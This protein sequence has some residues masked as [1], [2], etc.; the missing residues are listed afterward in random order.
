[1][2]VLV[3]VESFTKEK[4]VK[5]YLTKAFQGDGRTF[6]V[7]ASGGH[8]C[9]LVKANMGISERTLEPVYEIIKDKGKHVSDLKRLVSEH[10]VVYLASDND[11]EGEAIAW[12][13]LK[14]L[15]PKIYKRIVFNE[16]TMQALKNAVNNPRDVNLHMV[17]SQQAR[18]VLDRLV[19]YNLTKVLWKNFSGGGMLTAGRVQSVVL[20]MLVEREVDVAKFETERYWNV[21]GT[22]TNGVEEAK[23]CFENTIHK[24]VKKDEMLKVLQGFAKKNEYFVISSDTKRVN[25]YPN[26]PLTTSTLQQAAFSKGFSIKETMKVAQE[27]YEKGHITYMRTDST[28]LSEEFV[29][30]AKAHVGRVFGNDYVSPVSRKSERK[31][32]NAQEAHEAVRPT[33]NKHGELSLPSEVSGLNER[34]RKL[35][36]LIYAHTVASIMTPAVYDELT[37]RVGHDS[38]TKRGLYFRGKTR[39]LLFLGY[40]RVYGERASDSGS[41]SAKIDITSKKPLRAKEIRGNC[42]WTIPPQRYN[43]S[44]VIKAMEDNGIGRPSTYVNILNKVYDRSYVQKMDMRGPI[45]VYKDYV[46]KGA[47]KIDEDIRERELYVETNK[48]VPTK[49]GHA[50]DEFLR[51]RFSELVNV[52]FT[53]DMESSLDSIAEKHTT[54]EAVIRPFHSMLSAKVKEMVE[55]VGQKTVIEQERHVFKIDNESMVVRRAR[56]GPVIELVDSKRFIPLQPYMKLYGKSDISEIG[57]RDIKFLLGFPRAYKH[58][59]VNYKSYGFYVEN[60]RSKKTLSI[61]AFKNK[62]YKDQLARGELS[63]IDELKL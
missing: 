19:G 29:Q 21:W 7:K 4:T 13:L 26:K 9:D 45:K 59:T 32:K 8:I 34:Q 50:V 62:Q 51:K 35:Y 57:E 63:F 16:I 17:S 41:S 27:L 54:Y 18:R 28:N 2:K 46:L 31:Q 23:L 5:A 22:F 47:G 44:S 12:H 15:K 37:V 3:I 58:Y 30:S 14:V 56:Y 49:S 60:D 61:N 55:D 52:K 25:E 24:F 6:T 40:L 10:D 53:G 36:T 42:V 1:M 11:R 20:K 43:E 38:L 39:K 48:L 33:L